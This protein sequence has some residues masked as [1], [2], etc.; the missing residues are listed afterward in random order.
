MGFF[1]CHVLW[2]KKNGIIRVVSH[3]FCCQGVLL[4]GSN[5]GLRQKPQTKQQK[6]RSCCVKVH[7]GDPVLVVPVSPIAPNPFTRVSRCHTKGSNDL[8]TQNVL[9][10]TPTPNPKASV[11]VV[12]VGAHLHGP[13]L[14]AVLRKQRPVL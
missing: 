2:D 5:L 1:I 3:N 10:C 12:V 8:Y 6:L 13:T 9:G 14:A 4:K 7:T 11:V